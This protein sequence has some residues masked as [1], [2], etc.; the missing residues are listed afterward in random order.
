[1]KVRL[2]KDRVKPVYVTIRRFKNYDQNVLAKDVSMAPWSVVDV[3]DH[4]DDKV[5]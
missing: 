2:K 3:F 5:P 4:V 1:M